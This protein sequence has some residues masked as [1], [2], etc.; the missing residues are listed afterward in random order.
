MINS[1]L[2]GAAR[3]ARVSGVAAGG[4]SGIGMVFETKTLD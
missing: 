2:T 3:W 1:I 4:F